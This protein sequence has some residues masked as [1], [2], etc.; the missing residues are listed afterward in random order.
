LAARL[1]KQDEEKVTP[2]E[3]DKLV[4]KFA[5][6]D[7]KVR[8][9]AV[10]ALKKVGTRADST[11]VVALLHDPD[12]RVRTAAA[13][14]LGELGGKR[15]LIALEIRLREP[16]ASDDPAFDAVAK[17]KKAVAERVEADDKKLKAKPPEKK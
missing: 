2:T 13:E 3:A 15:E 14:W 16:K 12:A 10:E 11:A 6:A 8:A 1:K 9:G 17:A 7:A 5:D 4:A